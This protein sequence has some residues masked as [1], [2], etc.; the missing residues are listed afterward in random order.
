LNFTQ[1]TG[2][3]ANLLSTNEQRFLPCIPASAAN[4][5]IVVTSGAPGAGGTVSVTTWGFRK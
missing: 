2:T 5:P 4:T 1:L 3:C